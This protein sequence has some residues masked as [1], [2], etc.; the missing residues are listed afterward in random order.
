[1]D[2]TNASLEKYLRSLPVNQQETTLSFEQIEGI[3]NESLPLSARED[4]LWWG[5]QKQGTFVET[6]PW[7]SAGW[8]VDIVNLA[9][10][11]VRFVR[12]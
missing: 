4:E 2:D 11:W 10:K 8:L 12:Q 1:M 3:L 7:M 5:N 6:I 9:Q